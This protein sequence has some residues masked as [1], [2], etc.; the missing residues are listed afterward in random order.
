MVTEAAAVIQDFAI[1]MVIASV[2]ALVFYKIKQPMVIGYIAAGMLIGPYTPPFSLITHPEV[3]NLLAEI[4]IVLLLFVVGLEYPIAKL[5]SVGKRALIIAM[6]EAFGTLALGYVVGQAMGLALFDSLFLALSISVTSTVIVMRV[7]EALGMIKDPASALLLG[8]AVIVD[9]IVVSVLAVLQSVAA[10]G[11]L[12]FQD[13]GISIGLVLAFIGGVLFI[14]SKTVPKFVDII[15]RTNH[16]DLVVAAVLGMAF[17]LSFIANQ[18]GISVAAGA[19]FA[20]VLVA[21]SKSHAVARVLSMP[22]R[23]C[24]QPCSLSPSAR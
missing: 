2:M 14:G 21:E 9:I 4:G 13:I 7:L 16:H 10:T 17:G 22:L 19:F 8:V 6:V 12:A 20:G 3:V 24:L 18:I 23:T 1:V 11:N 5:H 15:G